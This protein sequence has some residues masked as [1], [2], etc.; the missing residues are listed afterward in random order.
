MGNDIAD[1][2]NDGLD[3]V[4]TV[5]MNPEDNFRKKKNMN[6]YNYFIYQNILNQG[7]EPQYVRNTLQ[8]NMGPRLLENDSVG[9]PVFADIGFYAGVAQTDWSWT[10][11]L[12][13]FDNDG[14]RDLII[15]N[16][17]P[18]D[19][20]DHDFAA[21]RNK[22]T[23]LASKKEIIDQIPQIKIPNYAYKNT[24]NLKFEDVTQ[25]WG[26]NEISF[27]SGAVY[28]PTWTMM[29]ILIML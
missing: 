8:L 13:D 12:A 6:R 22:A 18:R 7:L 15:T 29:V 17:Y 19:V 28:T 9:D 26:M 21:F 23:N 25:Q 16:G 2:N 5:D 24:G 10:P 1:I 3:D 14:Y 4:I 20:T 27:S 11:S